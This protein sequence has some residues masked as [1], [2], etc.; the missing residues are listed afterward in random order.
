ME[1]VSLVDEA[2][3]FEEKLQSVDL[4]EY[5][6]IFFIFSTCCYLRI[7]ASIGSLGQRGKGGWQAGSVNTFSR[8]SHT[9]P[10]IFRSGL[11]G[12]QSKT[13]SVSKYD[14]TSINSMLGILF[15][16]IFSTVQKSK[17]TECWFS[18]M[19]SSNLKGDLSSVVTWLHCHNNLYPVKNRKYSQ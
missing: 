16:L 10:I 12:R 17:A 11:C 1:C 9:A 13:V 4:N 14:F 15:F 5:I 8:W 7:A 3:V 6:S 2:W 18:V 19:L